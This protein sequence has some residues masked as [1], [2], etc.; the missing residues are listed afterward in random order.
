MPSFTITG[1]A[2][3]PRDWETA[4]GQFRSYYLKVEGDEKTY[5]LAQ[6][7]DK[8]APNVGDTVDATVE[9]REVN[10]VTYYK[11]K[12]EYQQRGGGGNGNR[13]KDPAERESIERQVAAKVASDLLVALMAQGTFKPEGVDGLG[14]AHTRLA[15]QVAGGIKG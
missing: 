3:A 4:N 8:P 7:R 1:F 15:A 10:D 2:S 5:E 14:Q 12:R 13:S 9:T 11:L 6:K